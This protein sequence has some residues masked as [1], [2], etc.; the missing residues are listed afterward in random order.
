MAGFDSIGSCIRQRRTGSASGMRR[1]TPRCNVFLLLQLARCISLL[2]WHSTHRRATIRE[3][4]VLLPFLP[5]GLNDSLAVTCR[6]SEPSKLFQLGLPLLGLVYNRCGERVRASSP[7]M[8]A[9]VTSSSPSSPP[10]VTGA[11]LWMICP[12]FWTGFVIHHAHGGC[13]WDVGKV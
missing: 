2:T 8:S 4:F 12:R 5:S 13:F 6:S 7:I 1:E 9:I 3:L 11:A 10:V